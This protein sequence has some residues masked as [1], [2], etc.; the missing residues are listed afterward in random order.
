MFEKNRMEAYVQRDH[1]GSNST[2]VLVS[3]F[4]NTTAINSGGR[5]R[6]DAGEEGWQDD[7]VGYTKDFMN[8]LL[9]FIL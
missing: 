3:G 7:P 5:R 6:R 2:G 8:R 1:L 4:T 9:D